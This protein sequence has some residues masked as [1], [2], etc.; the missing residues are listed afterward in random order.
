M[1]KELNEVAVKTE[2]A[3]VVQH[4]EKLILPSAMT[5]ESAVE[6][7][8]KFIEHNEQEVIVVEDYDV[9]PWDGANGLF[10]V[11]TQKFGWA[12]AVPVPGLF[13]P[14][15]PTTVQV[16]V[17][18][19]QK[20]S[21]IWGD[22]SLPGIPGRLSCQS[23]QGTGGR[24]IFRLAAKVKRKHEGM[25]REICELLRAELKVNSLYRGKALRIRFN[26]DDGRALDMPEIKFLD[27]ASVRPE[28]LIL[29]RHLYDAIETNLYTPITRVAELRA[30][31]IPVKRGVLLGGTYGTGKTL[32]ASV[33]SRIATD[34]GVTYLAVDRADEL[35]DAIEFAKQYSSTACVVFC[36]DIDREVNGER[37]VEMDDL[38]NIID[39]IDSKSSNL[40]M[41]LTTNDLQ[42]INPAMLRPGRLDAVI[43]VTAPDAEAIERLLRYYGGDCISDDL[44]LSQVGSVLEGCIPAVVEEVVKRAKL[45]QLKLNPRGQLV[46]DLTVQALLESAETMKGQ[47]KLLKDRIEVKPSEVNIGDLIGQA[48]VEKFNGQIKEMGEHIVR[49]L[50]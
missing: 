49:A 28:K 14:R 13:G 37:S 6:L 22:F 35:A 11:L 48:V 19:N 10:N 18:Y 3:Q 36:E 25:V 8:M 46:Q 27:V 42:G 29:S 9:F 23:T 4:G 30:N 24:T 12:T 43:E 26:A 21:I 38:L 40:I 39:G 17:G 2:F 45:A 15:P 7:L 31:N 32:A 20:K 1:G 34:V 5:P 44:D 47:L 50:S 41:V 33:A 16:E